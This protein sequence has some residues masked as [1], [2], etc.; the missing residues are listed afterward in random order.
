MAKRHPPARA[1]VGAA[2]A[3]A[4]HPYT[5]Q[6]RGAAVQTVSGLAAAKP[7][8]VRREEFKAKLKQAVTDAMQQ[9]KTE[10]Q[11]TAV[12]KEGGHKASKSLKADLSVERD[13]A[14]GPLEAA[15]KTEAPVS[16]QPETGT[17]LHV[18]PPGPPPASVSPD[19]VVP[20]PLSAER[21]DYSADR[22]PTDRAMAQDDVTQD[23]L[24]KGND[25]AFTP[26]LDSR[27]TAEKHE[28]TAEAQYR[29]QE[30]AVQGAAHGDAAVALTHGL[31]G[32]HAGRTARLEKVGGKQQDL[33]DRDAL[34][35]QAITDRVTGI[36]NETKSKVDA[37]LKQIDDEAPK[38][39]GTGLARAE[40]AYDAAFEEAKGGVGTWLTTWGSDWDDL[41]TRALAT[42]RAEYMGQVDIAIDEVA[43]LVDKKL[44]EAKG[45]VAAGRREV[46]Q[47]VDGLDKHLRQA[48]EAAR[49]AVSGDFDAMAAQID[50]HRDALVSKL[51]QQYKE[52][53]ER[54]SA[55]EEE[56]REA[57]KSLWQRVYDATVGLV[58]KIIEFKNMLLSALSRAAGVISDI[59]HHPIRFLGNLVDAIGLGLK[60]FKSN[61]A[62]HLKRGLME[63]IFGALSGAGIQLPEAFD[64]KG[65]LSIV[66]QVLG[67][68]YANFRA[69]AVAIVGETVVSALE[70]AAGVFKIFMT[71]GVAGLWE[72]IKEKVSDLKSMVLDA[73]FDFIKEKVITA[74]ITW[75]IGLLNPVSAFFK[76]CK[77]IYDIVMF[78]INHASQIMELVN[79]IINSVSAIVKGNITAAANWVENALAKIIPLAIGFLA[80][81]LG[82]GDPSKTVKETIEKAQ[83]PVNKAID[84][85][86]HGAVKLVKAA[87]QFVKGVF[88]KKDKG[89]DTQHE[90]DPA[91]AAR[92]EAG[93]AH[94]HRLEQEREKNGKLTGRDAED[95]VADTRVK[96]GV[97]SSLSVKHAGD[98][99]LYVYT[100][101]AEQTVTGANVDP[102]EVTV[103]GTQIYV[104]R[105]SDEVVRI[106]LDETGA[107]AVS[108]PRRASDGSC[109]TAA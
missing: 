107:G 108:I 82:L 67:L 5:E 16:G 2:Q 77:A 27:A 44:S 41:I 72:F 9:P 18:Q 51:A 61:I 23:Q 37:V 59:I 97:F 6:A 21:L 11:A 102:E 104:F 13:A 103:E 85:V 98:H 4:I 71:Q 99:W 105:V 10:A 47:F 87:G 22:E 69:R 1:A 8:A 35:R 17:E 54:M 29:G 73:I 20:A 94:I 96:H 76:A 57:N 56:L 63:W 55:R 93:I 19:S 89:K 91:K 53:Y 7:Q 95:I 75:I 80:S 79:A 109:F 78:F 30:R 3:A 46:D 74:G 88:G 58:K 92:V 12:M 32:I 36:K 106:S 28:A 42:A 52:S 83:A 33:K 15:A 39:F 60:N 84:W 26:T 101:S 62:M 68:T 40:K 34:K 24:K 45:C 86:I 43:D 81:L 25:P 64:L 14:V 70:Q 38:I 65:I 48:G 90:D 66:L 50:E 31:G 100:A 49:D